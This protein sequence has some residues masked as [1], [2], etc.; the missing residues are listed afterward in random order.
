MF[1]EFRDKFNETKLRDS[2]LIRAMAREEAVWVIL[3]TLDC[4]NT[5]YGKGN[6]QF[7]EKRLNICY[8]IHTDIFR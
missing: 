5:V 4:S 6:V 8:K 7:E 2:W 1:R 3:L